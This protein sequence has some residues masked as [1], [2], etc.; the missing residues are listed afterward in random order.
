MGRFFPTVYFKW[1]E[2]GPAA[3]QRAADWKR[4]VWLSLAAFVPFVLLLLFLSC[5][6]G[7]ERFPREMII[8]AAAGVAVVLF[9]ASWLMRWAPRYVRVTERGVSVRCGKHVRY[10][11]WRR[12][13]AWRIDQREIEGQSFRI[14]CLTYGP[15]RRTLDL[16]IADLVPLKQLEAVLAEK[17]SPLDGAESTRPARRKRQQAY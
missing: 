7:S 16:G 9:A 8:P 17:C 12:L 11:P 5:L 15:K 4:Q 10:I 2:P 14:L 13:V 1:R 6:P 3:R